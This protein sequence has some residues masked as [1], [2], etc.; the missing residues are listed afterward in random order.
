MLEQSEPKNPAE[1]MIKLW[2]SW[3]TAGIEAMQRTA[4][5]F[6]PGAWQPEWIAGLPDQ[7]EKAM[8]ASLE[9]ARIRSAQDLQ[10]VVQELDTLRSTV[11]AMQTGLAALESLM[12]GQQEMWRAVENSVQ[13]ATKA[14]HEI[15]RAMTTWTRQWEDRL[16]GVTRGME[17]WRSR[18]EE[19]LRQG[20]AMSQASQKSLEDLTK[21]MWNLSQKVMGGQG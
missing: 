13:Q 8:R 17:E 5:L 18:W 3:M 14:Q 10:R 9:A 20:V 19:M 15:Q 7:I 16:A 2:Q 21:T 11:A 12:K 4:T 1:E 6:A